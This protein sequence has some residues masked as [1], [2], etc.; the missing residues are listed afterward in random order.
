MLPRLDELEA[1]LEDRKKRAATEGWLGEIEGWTGLCGASGTTCRRTSADRIT[2]QV[3]LGMP[4]L[5]PAR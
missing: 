2:R 5:A 1:D 4:V 3:D